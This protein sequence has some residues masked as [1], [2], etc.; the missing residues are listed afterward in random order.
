MEDFKTEPAK[1]GAAAQRAM[2]ELEQHYG[3]DAELLAVGIVVALVRD[4]EAII[5]AHVEPV[6]PDADVDPR[7]LFRAAAD[8]QF[9]QP[10]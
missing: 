10:S 7:A 2:D 9:G 6:R 3:P 8:A 1:L 5:H 4:G